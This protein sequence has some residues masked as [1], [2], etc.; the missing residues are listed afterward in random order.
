LGVYCNGCKYRKNE[1]EM[2]MGCKWDKLGGKW[3]WVEN[4]INWAYI[5]MG[6]NIGKMSG[7][8]KWVIFMIYWAGFLDF[9]FYFNFADSLNFS[10][11]IRAWNIVIIGRRR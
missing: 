1:R 7:K 11:W 5:A 10:Y 4:E 3:K 6:A 2:K 9:I 8:L